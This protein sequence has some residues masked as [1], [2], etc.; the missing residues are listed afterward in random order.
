VARLALLGVALALLAACGGGDGADA[1][2]GGPVDVELVVVTG[3][4]ASSR[5]EVRCDPAGGTTPAPEETC[6]AIAGHPEMLA[7]P[8]LESSCP[9][10]LG[11]P[12]EVRIGGMAAGRPVDVAMRE[13]DEPEAR[14]DAARLWLEAAGLSSD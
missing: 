2:A 10:S 8:P 5:F 6:A 7:P 14:A 11:N 12:P 4:D 3:V 1:S 9:G 13:C